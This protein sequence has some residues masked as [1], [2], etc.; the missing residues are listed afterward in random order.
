MKSIFMNT[1]RERESERDPPL[2]RNTDLKPMPF[3]PIYPALDP[4]LVEF[5]TSQ[6]ALMFS[7]E[8]P[9]SLFKTTIPDSWRMNARVGSTFVG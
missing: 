7:A 5:P 6:S 1:E 8:K 3:F 9:R 4:F 2:T